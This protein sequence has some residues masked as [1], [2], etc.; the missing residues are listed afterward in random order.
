M[1]QPQDPLD[2]REEA[3]LRGLLAAAG[4]P[5]LEFARGVFQAA[6]SAP[7]RLLPP[8]WLGLILGDDSVDAVSLRRLFALCMRD[9]NAC[10]ECLTLGVPV[11]PRP[12]DEAA[13]SEFC[14]GYVRA[15]QKDKRWTGNL[16][17]FELTVPFA[18]LAGYL[19][20]SRV[21]ELLRD[22]S[23]ESAATATPDPEAWRAEQRERLADSVARA[24]DFWSEARRAQPAQAEEKPGRNEPCPCGS[25]KKYKRCC[26]A[27]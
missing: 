14:R 17:A 23:A 18:V 1:Q 3:E 10:A 25:G 12:D 11:V 6:A 27:G 8:D 22:R 15:T 24:F 5:S 21:L 2:E 20:E 7:S 26:G 9:Y 16:E 4:A 19:D 13:V